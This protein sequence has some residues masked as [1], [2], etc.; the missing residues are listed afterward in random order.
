MAEVVKM[1]TST[2]AGPSERSFSPYVSNGGTTMAVAGEDFCVIAGDTR[3]SS[4][5]SIQCRSVSKLFKLTDHCVLGTSG[6]QAEA[7]TL[8]KMLNYKITFYDHQHHQEL[9][10]PGVA[11]MLSNTLYYKR[12]F[13]YYTFNV[14]GGVTPEGK[15]VCYGYDAVGSF[16]SSPYVVTGTA[17]ALI[18]SILDNQ[19][20]FKTQPS[21][22]KKLSLEETIDLVKDCFAI[23]CERDMF[24]GDSVDIAVVTSKGVEI[25]TEKEKFRLRED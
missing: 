4:G 15:G 7:T 10:T 20:A 17:S 21:N 14:L 22:F 8:W 19:V 11:Q 16:E 9:A 24:T 13:P 2:V 3:M 18:T 6:M 25:I 12:F 1:H 5:Y 23:A